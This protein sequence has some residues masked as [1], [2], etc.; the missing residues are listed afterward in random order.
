VSG[1]DYNS[2]ISK[3]TSLTLA[4]TTALNAQVA[5]LNAANVELTKINTL[6]QSVQN[7]LGAL[8]NPALYDQYSATS[9]DPTALTASGISG[10]SAVPGTYVIQSVKTATATT[11]TSS[12]SAVHNINDTITSGNYAGQS[13]ATVPLADSYAAVTPSNG[14]TGQGVFTVDG[15]SIR[16]DVGSQSLDTILQNITNAVS[17]TVDHGFLATLSSSGVVEFESS[18][19]PISVGS[20]VDVGNLAQVLQISNAY[21]SNSSTSGSVIGTTGVGGLNVTNDINATPGPNTKTAITAGSFTI[22]GVQIK[23]S[24]DQNVDDVLTSINDS[25]A[26]VTASYNSTTGQIELVSTTPGALSIVLGSSSDTSNFLSAVGLTAASGA[27]TQIGTQS[28]VTVVNPNGSTQTYYNNSNTVTNAIAGLQLNLTDSTTTPT[29]ITVA[30]DTTQLVNALTTFVSVYNTAISEINSATAAPVVTPIQPG[31]NSVGSSVGGGVLYDNSDVQT[32]QQELTSIVSG[33]FGNSQQYIGD[34]NA[35]SN[36]LFSLSQVGL[37]LDD[38]FSQ[39]TTSDNSDETGN[40]GGSSTSSSST[41]SSTSYEG[42]DGQLQALDV[43]KLEAAFAANPTGVQALFVGD[44][45]LT[46]QLGSY[47]TGVTGTPTLLNSGTVGTIPPISIL[48]NFE[49]TNTDTITNVQQQIAQ[50]T[51]SANSQAN[52]LRD[53]FVASETTIAQLQSEQQELASALGFTIS[54]SS[55]SSS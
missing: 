55:S 22:N 26:G 12:L 6:L 38:S 2:V 30:T 24:A 11:V 52:D 48:Q 29:T 53:Q 40:T 5:T 36:T 10:V 49:D 27:T 43:A 46:T 8:S 1:I 28:Q 42:T 17:A 4:P 51:D 9:S 15:V 32:I 50:I 14:G 39:L 3:L 44:D 13:S 19:A 35:P 31:T 47:L 41:V 54:S 7:S 18:D 21:V 16:Y 45:G 33:F 20:A 34:S 25:G 23:V 37:Q